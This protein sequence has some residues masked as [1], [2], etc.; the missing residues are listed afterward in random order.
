MS[1]TADVVIQDT[2]AEVEC[3]EDEWKAITAGNAA[4]RSAMAIMR[5]DVD[6]KAL[7]EQSMEFLVTD[8]CNKVG[9]MDNFMDMSQKITSQIDLENGVFEQEGLKMLEQWEQKADSGALLKPSDKKRILREAADPSA[10]I[11]SLPEVKVSSY[12]NV[13]R[14]K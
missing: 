6:K 11:E 10:D 4:M 2:E 7:F 3:K 5:G 13:L 9:E 12:K 8:I 1:E 14:R